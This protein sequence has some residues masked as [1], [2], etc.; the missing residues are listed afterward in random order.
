MAISILI[1]IMDLKHSLSLPLVR[2]KIKCPC[3]KTRCQNTSFR[4]VDDVKVH[5]VRWGFVDDYFNWRLHGEEDWG[6][7]NY[8]DPQ[9]YDQSTSYGLNTE[10]A[11][12]SY[13]TMVRDVAGPQFNVGNI[14]EP[15]NRHAQQFYDMLSAADQD[16][17]PGCKT[18]S[19]LSFN[20]RLM[21]IKTEN[22]LS[23]RG[24]NQITQL[25]SEICPPG[26]LVPKRFYDSKKLMKGMG[27]PVERIDCCRQGC[28][29]YWGE[30]SELDHCKVCS[31]PRYK[32]RSEKSKIAVKTMFYFP[33]IPRLQRLYQSN[34]S[35]KDMTWH[36]NSSD[37]DLDVMCHPADPLAWK[38]FNRAFP[39]FASEIRNVRL[40]LSTDG[41]Q[42]FG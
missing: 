25:C 24:F 10:A 20:A 12:S 23:E 26:N 39:D 22:R 38:H 6:Q 3:K 16:L 1:F 17:Y 7:T 21:N 11:S 14:E 31:A 5:L 19:Q 42:P 40:G 36:A 28:M 27:L 32:L 29:L 15:P 37:D 35:A 9:Y 34:A 18:H 13:H 2:E 4:K 8:Q 30:D 33:L 41:F